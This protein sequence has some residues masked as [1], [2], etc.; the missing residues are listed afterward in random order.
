MW[1]ARGLASR[2]GACRPGVDSLARRREDPVVKATYALTCANEPCAGPK[3]PKPCA[4]PAP[5]ERERR[6]LAP[7]RMDLV[8]AAARYEEEPEGLGDAFLERVDHAIALIA[9][10]VT[11]G[12]RSWPSPP[13]GAVR[14]I[15]DDERIALVCVAIETQQEAALRAV[16]VTK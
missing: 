4:G 14:F 1:K 5:A 6:F 12:S 15:V 16:T 2:V 7:A 9:A 13:T 10:A 8:A 3:P 11:T